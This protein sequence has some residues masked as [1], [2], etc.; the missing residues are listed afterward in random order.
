MEKLRVLVAGLALSLAVTL[1]APVAHAAGGGAYQV[2]L[3][4]EKGYSFTV[5]GK[6]AAQRI[7]PWGGAIVMYCYEYGGTRARM[8]SFRIPRTP[9]NQRD[10]ARLSWGNRIT[11]DA[12]LPPGQERTETAGRVDL[13]FTGAG[14]RRVSGTIDL[15]VGNCYATGMAVTG[16]ARQA[17]TKPKPKRAAVP[18]QRLV[19]KGRSTAVRVRCPK[20]P[21]RACRGT[22]LIKHGKTTLAKRGYAV[23]AGQRRAVKVGLTKKGRRVLNRQ[24]PRR[25]TVVLNPGK[26]A[27]NVTRKV[28]IRLR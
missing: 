6:G 24:Q 7:A 15:R 13:R 4:G 1:V 26:G 14:G 21:Q 16:A 2:V 5:V 22:L 17:A 12:D 20:N 3:K 23:K 27:K 19:A 28:R 10:Q 11:P 9:I 25:V 8:T 18:A